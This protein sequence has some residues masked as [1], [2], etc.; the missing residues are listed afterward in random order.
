MAL[1]SFP[2]S[3]RENLGP[4]CS[5]S[6]LRP[7]SRRQSVLNSLV[8]WSGREHALAGM[9][10]RDASHAAHAKKCWTTRSAHTAPSFTMSVPWSRRDELRRLLFAFVRFFAFAAAKRRWT[11]RQIRWAASIGTSSSAGSR[12][13]YDLLF[14]TWLN[15]A[16]ARLPP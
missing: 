9:W 11:C 1:M 4:S 12:Q 5:A 13:T 3:S 14:R 15:G 6:R 7:V 8:Q 16:S 2:P 10:P